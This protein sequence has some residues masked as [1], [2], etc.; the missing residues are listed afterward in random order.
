MD[1]NRTETLRDDEFGREDRLRE[2]VLPDGTPGDDTLRDGT[3]RDDAL[4]DDRA[5]GLAD[6][7]IGRADLTDGDITLRAERLVPGAERREW[8]RV[9]VTRRIVTEERTITVPVRREELVVEYLGDEPAPKADQSTVR[10]S[11]QAVDS[12]V[13]EEY[14]LHEEVPR[15]ELDVVAKERVQVLVDSQQSLVQMSDTVR[16]EELA[17]NET[18]HDLD[19]DTR[20]GLDAD[21]R[22]GLAG[23]PRRGLDDDRRI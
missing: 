6:D 1:T 15:V 13:V 18:R 16:R 23:D 2:G 9:K 5:E 4:R 10:G 14:V 20:P 22:Q 21:S 3:V 17:V 7:R 11:T 19:A 8:A 12:R